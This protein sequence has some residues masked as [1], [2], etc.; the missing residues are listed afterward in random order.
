MPGRRACDRCFK[1]KQKCNF[2]DGEEAC[3]ECELS[4]SACTSSR[5]R[6][7]QGRRPKVKKL[8]PE[9]SVQV[10][11]VKSPSNSIVTI[12][13][14]LNP[15]GSVR[16]RD[17]GS[18]SRS[19]VAPIE[20]YT[21]KPQDLHRLLSFNYWGSPKFLTVA[22]LTLDLR[23][24]GL[25]TYPISHDS[26]LTS[27]ASPFQ[28]D[29]PEV[30]KLFTDTYDLFMLGPSFAWEMRAAFQHSYLCSPVLL[31]D[32]IA[33][34]WATV[35]RARNNVAAWD[36]DDVA[37]GAV[38]LQQLR[39]AKISGIGDAL[40][41][42]ALGQTLAAFDLLT[43]CNGSTSILRYS[44]ASISPW[45]KGV[46]MNPKLDPVIIASVFWDTLNCLFK[47]EVPII[48]H[49][50]RDFP[51]VDR[52]AGLC[53][54]LLP[55]F[56][57]LCVASKTS[58]DNLEAGIEVDICRLEQIQ[59]K[60]FWWSPE[61]QLTLADNF[62]NQEILKMEAQA[63]MYRTAAL[64]FC[65]RTLHPIGTGDNIARDHAD[66]I[67]SDFSKYSA[68]LNPGERLQNVGFPILLVALE[69][70][71]L[72]KDIWKH[73]TLSAAAPIFEAKISAMI[74]WV[75]MERSNGSR[76]FLLDLVERGPD[77]VVIP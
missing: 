30:L 28:V 64:F 29:S 67:M 26:Q 10:W 4:K 41:I 17:L 47:R 18:P 42:L 43:S 71:D 59:Q 16:V 14:K 9:G 8:G 77:F 60:I 66:N 19:A 50:S 35:K 74:D 58:K 1:Y 72:P 39:T 40:A 61:P 44:L 51:V 13:K 52:M 33:V 55:I 6:V 24:S 36:Q 38:S 56:Y 62:S 48:K 7:R 69:I 22:E 15:E 68:M 5:L 46:A 11:D 57:D 23:E 49:I 65:H 63:S 76:N 21:Y 20:S 31:H 25:E 2:D 73:I 53:T 32:I 75:W 3:L 27:M 45:Y 54:T 37:R 12:T 34:L 70:Q